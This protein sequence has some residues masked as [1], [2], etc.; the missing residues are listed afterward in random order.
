MPLGN[1]SRPELP[2]RLEHSCAT[3]KW[4]DLPPPRHTRTVHVPGTSVTGGP[5]GS[6]G[7]A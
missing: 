2:A 7:L 5:G 1:T 6:T 3:E 4:G